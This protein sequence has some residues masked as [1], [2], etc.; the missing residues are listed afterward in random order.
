MNEEPQQLLEAPIFNFCF[1][2]HHNPIQ[3][4]VSHSMTIE[5]IHLMVSLLQRGWGTQASSSS[6]QSSC[7]FFTLR[8]A[9]WGDSGTW[10][11]SLLDTSLHT[12]WRNSWKDYMF[13]WLGN[14]SW[15]PR[16]NWKTWWWRRTSGLPHLAC[17]LN[18]LQ[19]LQ[20][21]SGWKFT[22]KRTSWGRLNMKKRIV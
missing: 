10:S 13:I 17:S 1:S 21:L 2:F 19:H 11:E 20:K 14:A 7:C 16:K 3:R 8:K 22:S 6:F 4:G 9:T 18:N 5:N 12:I 15:L